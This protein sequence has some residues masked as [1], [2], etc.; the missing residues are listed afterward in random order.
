VFKAEHRHMGTVR[1]IKVLLPQISGAPE[2]VARLITE[3]RATTRLRHAAIIEAFDCD[4][5]PDGRAFIVM[6][7]L[8]GEPM[9]RWLNRVG[10]LAAF[11][12]LASAL[13]GVVAGGLAFA[14]QHGIVHRD[15][16]PENL[17]LVPGE[18]GR[19]AVKILDFGVAKLLREE[20]LTRT[21]QGCVL[22]TPAYMAPEQWHPGRAVD[23]RAD[24]YALGCLLFELLCGRA[25]F[26]R[27]H[28]SEQEDDEASMMEAHLLEIPPEVASLEPDVPR[29]LDALLSRMLAKRPEDRPR[30]MEEII[31]ALEKLI[32]VERTQFA[33]LLRAPDGLATVRAVEPAAGEPTLE[34]APRP[35]PSTTVVVEKKPRG[36][37]VLLASLGALAVCAVAV[38]VVATSRTSPVAQHQ[39][40]AEPRVEAVRVAT[41]TDGAAV[42]KA[43]AIARPAPPVA[44]P[45]RGPQPARRRA[46]NSYRAVPD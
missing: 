45:A 8:H 13:T 38:A 39:E 34:R 2:L 20:P 24:I 31:V 33:G 1:A 44:K 35:P 23:H 25:P 11:P 17:F 36:R 4:I 19:F 10:K 32:G 22:G 7:W 3:A 40:R 27:A 9:N 28:G 6:E 30:D 41:P 14:H 42:S 15:L 37:L 26:E 16:K 46:A 29:E 5:L 21:R 12:R 18:G 43:P